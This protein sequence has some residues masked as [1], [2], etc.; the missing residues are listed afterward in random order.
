MSL[1]EAVAHLFFRLVKLAGFTLLLCFTHDLFKHLHR[2]KAALA[3]VTLDM[4]LDV[5]VRSDSDF[6]FALWHNSAIPVPDFQADRVARIGLFL[7]DDK[8]AGGHF[9]HQLLVNVLLH[10]TTA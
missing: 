1:V 3:L 10:D 8:S 2:F 5:A 6:K 9:V 4:Q 7:H